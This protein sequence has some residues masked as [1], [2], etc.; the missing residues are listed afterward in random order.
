MLGSKENLNGLLL[1]APVTSSPCAEAVI[2]DTALM[3]PVLRPPPCESRFTPPVL[4][5]TAPSTTVPAW[6]VTLMAASGSV[7]LAVMAPP[8]MSVTAVPAG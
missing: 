2:W 7:A 5:V 1:T 6:A 4:A 8:R 3:A